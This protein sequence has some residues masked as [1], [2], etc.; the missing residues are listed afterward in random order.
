MSLS[1]EGNVDRA[2]TSQYAQDSKNEQPWYV[3]RALPTECPGREDE[4][5]KSLVQREELKE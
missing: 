1:Y 5:C 2:L 3:R 4:R